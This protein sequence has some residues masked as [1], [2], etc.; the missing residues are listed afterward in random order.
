MAKQGWLGSVAFA[1]GS[2]AG[3]AA[4][5]FG[6]G[7]GFG[8]IAWSPDAGV[9]TTADNVWLSSLAWTLWIAANSTVIGAVAA[10]RR[11]AGEIGAAPPRAGRTGLDAD[12]PN[13]FATA[14]WRVLLAVAAAVGALLSVAL[15]LAPAHNAGR[16]DTTSPQLI[17]AGYAV[18]GVTVGIVL[19]V[20]AL[21]ARAAAGNVLITSLWLWLLAAG[22]VVVDVVKGHGYGTAALEVWPFGNTSYFRHTFSIDGAVLML[23]TAAV[24]GV[25]AAWPAARRSDNR[26]G[27]VL[28]GAAGPLLVAAA[29]V[30]TIPALVGVT[31]NPQA[32]ASIIAPYALLAGLAGS[33]L[34]VA[35]ISGREASLRDRKARGD[36]SSP[37]DGDLDTVQL[38]KPPP[39]TG[40][41]PGAS[42][43]AAAA[44]GMAPAL[45]AAKA[46]AGVAKAPAPRSSAD[47]VSGMA[48][49]PS[50]RSS[51]DETSRIPTSPKRASDGPTAKGSVTT[52]Q[53][54]GTSSSGPAKP[55]SSGPGGGN[56]NNKR[57]RRR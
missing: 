40:I 7:Y 5:Q 38:R 30:L 44:A 45:A 26:I 20:C 39:A 11:S 4:A 27:V 46:K 18:V 32:S 21:S 37:G 43:P 29:Y 50:M 57:G 2:G 19:A 56:S 54:T 53:P 52:T 8:V 24:I 35:A 51:D 17:V 1:V 55:G 41:A 12:R 22:S 31:G 14:I 36:S 42:G 34:L 15:V 3:A 47:T 16:P 33:G 49:V 10:D 13:A 9:T 6:L 48:K 25:G 23:L 28:S